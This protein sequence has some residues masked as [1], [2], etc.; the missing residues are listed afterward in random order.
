MGIGPASVIQNH[1][2]C[3]VCDKC[4]GCCS[5]AGKN[6]LWVQCD[7]CGA[8]THILVCVGAQS[9]Y[10]AHC[11]KHQFNNGRAWICPK[12]RPNIDLQQ[13]SPLPSASQHTPPPILPPSL[14]PGENCSLFSPLS[15]ISSS[16]LPNASLAHQGRLNC[17]P[18]QPPPL[19]PPPTRVKFTTFQH[20]S[21]YLQLTPI[22]SPE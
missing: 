22:Q 8:W 17:L 1:Y 15:G 14:Q 21:T 10:E 12:C 19:L 9:L 4:I 7:G 13:Y 6:V 16:S 5:Q 3:V 18:V 11:M 2:N 20:Y